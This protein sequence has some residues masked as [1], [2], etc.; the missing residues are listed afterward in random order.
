MIQL[1]D[2]G[3]DIWEIH[4]EKYGIF[5]SSS[6][7]VFRKAIRWGIRYSDLEYAIDSM[8]KNDHDYADFGMYNTFIFSAKMSDIRKVS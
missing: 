6:A 3:N 5:K 2:L 7:L 1:Y 8:L 4:S